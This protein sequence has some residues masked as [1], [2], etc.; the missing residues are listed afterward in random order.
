[1]VDVQA[2]KTRLEERLAHLA[3]LLDKIEHDL[4]SPQNPDFEERATERENDEVLEE[5]GS[6]GLLEIKQIKAALRRIE[7]G[8]FGLCVACG[9]PIS[10]ER[11]DAVPHAARC[12]DCA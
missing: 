2:Y 9:E 10:E 8:S 11:L 3:G 12:R 1:M 5:I 6:T 7:D 4:D